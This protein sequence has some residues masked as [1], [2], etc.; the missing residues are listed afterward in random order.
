MPLDLYV[1][2]GALQEEMELIIKKRGM[3]K[4]FKGIY[5]MPDTKPVLAK[6][7]MTENKYTPT[8]VLIENVMTWC[9]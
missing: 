6:W 1:I 9:Q 2:S 7:I 5:G 4:Y 3:K 8:K